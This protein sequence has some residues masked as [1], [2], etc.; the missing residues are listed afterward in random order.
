MSDS[1]KKKKEPTFPCA[2]KP[3]YCLNGSRW[4]ALVELRRK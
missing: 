4:E 3:D 1:I 2:T